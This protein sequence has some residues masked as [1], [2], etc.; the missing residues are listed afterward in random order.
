MEKKLQA[1]VGI[2]RGKTRHINNRNTFHKSTSDK[3]VV[4]S[5]GAVFGVNNKSVI[6]GLYKNIKSLGNTQEMASIKIG[7]IILNWVGI[8]I[9][10]YTWA[11]SIWNVDETKQWTL[12][13][14]SLIFGIVKTYHAYENARGKRIDNDERMYGLNK[15]HQKDERQNRR[16][17]K[18]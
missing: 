7:W 17:D 4:R 12:L 18:T 1:V 5:N 3:R 8:P 14:L 13:A 11:L 16:N 15:E 2:F 9:Y 6:D 10:L